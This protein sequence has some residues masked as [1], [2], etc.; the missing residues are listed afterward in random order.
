M[1]KYNVGDR[2]FLED[3][4]TKEVFDC[5]VT[6]VEPRQYEYNGKITNF[7]MLHTGSHTMTEDYNCL[8]ERNPKVIEY[9][10]T[11]KDPRIFINK[12]QEFLKENNFDIQSYPI[13][14]YLSELLWFKK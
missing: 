6:K 8:S 9:K 2:I 12:F 11:H 10:K 4:N 7:N 14:E 5:I 13:Q 3:W 1:K